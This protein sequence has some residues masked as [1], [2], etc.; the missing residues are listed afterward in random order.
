MHRTAAVISK[1]LAKRPINPAIRCTCK[2]S[3]RSAFVSHSHRSTMVQVQKALFQLEKQGPLVL[4]DT[5]IPVPGPEEILVEVCATALN[6]IDWKIQR[7]VRDFVKEYPV[8]FGF[9]SAGVVK[10]TG[11][12]VQSFVTGDT[13]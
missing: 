11:E 3:Q 4:Q 9:G 7:G 6:P 10:A 1:V 13:V 12:G 8:I 5:V 2:R